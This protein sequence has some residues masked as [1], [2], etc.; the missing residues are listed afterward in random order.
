MSAEPVCPSEEV[1]PIEPSEEAF[2]WVRRHYPES[3]APNLTDKQC[4]KFYRLA[5]TRE[6]LLELVR[7]GIRSVEE[8]DQILE[9]SAQ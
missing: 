2:E 7:C 8:M 4:G 3:R 5:Q 1:T 9:R 6:M